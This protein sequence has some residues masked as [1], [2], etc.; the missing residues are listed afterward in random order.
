MI[1]VTRRAV[2]EYNG[3]TLWRPKHWHTPFFANNFGRSECTRAR[4][5]LRL[6]FGFGLFWTYG[7]G[8]IE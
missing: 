3:F 8:W 7:K 4:L 1:R 5:L 6:P 2:R